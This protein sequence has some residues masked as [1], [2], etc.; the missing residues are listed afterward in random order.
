MVRIAVHNAFLN[1]LAVGTLSP[2]V[3]ATFQQLRERR[4]RAFSPK[5]TPAPSAQL[6][7]T[8]MSAKFEG[9]CMFLAV[10][11]YC[12]LNLSVFIAV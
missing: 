2:C 8:N 12:Y 1:T 3:P 11:F 7:V 5:M 4:S 9:S 10:L 6:I